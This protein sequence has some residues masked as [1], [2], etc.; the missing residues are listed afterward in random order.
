MCM[1]MKCM[2]K[3]CCIVY[4]CSYLEGDAGYFKHAQQCHSII[5]KDFSCDLKLRIEK[6]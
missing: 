1:F 2:N 5:L 3:V 6:L 4:P